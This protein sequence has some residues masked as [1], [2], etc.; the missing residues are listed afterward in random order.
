MGPPNQMVTGD[1]GVYTFSGV[2]AGRY[3]LQVQKV[4]FVPP[5][6]TEIPLFQVGAGQLV[7]VANLLLRKGGA[8]SGRVLDARGEP[9][10]EVMVSAVRP[11]PP[12]NGRGRLA[13]IGPAGQSGQTNDI[14][15]FRIS[16]LSAGDYYVAASPRP[17]SPF[18]Q[19]TTSSATTLVT[20]FYP[21]AL[22][23]SG[24]QAITVGAGQ[25]VGNLE[26]TIMSAAGYSVSGIVVDEMNS[27]V[28]GAMV[29]LMPTEL[30]GPG[31][32]GSGRTLPDG[33]FKIAGVVPGTYRLNASVPV[34]F[35]SSSGGGTVSGGVVGGVT[36]GSGGIVSYSSLPG[37][38]TIQVTV[39]D[40]DVAGV[41]VVVRKP[42]R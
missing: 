18:A 39:G 34:T 4:G 27:P 6:P 24:A 37:S 16:G 9:M 38:G 7:P 26:F 29:M 25:T 21:G 22:T 5:N 33:T 12:A 23:M 14:G 8:I 19:S 36:S 42:A 2:A 28:G 35:S 32:R 13:L 30:V 3:R 11:P 31:P 1:D 15:E 17:T 41:T 10:A 20:T 40:G